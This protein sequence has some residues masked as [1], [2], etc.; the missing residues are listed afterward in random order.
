MAESENSNSKQ[1]YIY[2]ALIALL[3]GGLIYTQVKL[4]QSKEEIKRTE[5]EKGQLETMRAELDKKYQDAMLEIENYRASNAG[6]DSLLNVKEHELSEKRA[7]IESLLAQVA[8]LKQSGKSD[9]ASMQKLIDEANSLIKELEADKARTQNSID[10]LITANK[11]LFAERDSITGE[12]TTTKIKKQVSEEENKLMK[13]RIDRASILSTANLQ[14]SAVHTKRNGKEDETSKAKD[15][16]KLKICFD[17]LQNKIAPKGETEIM[18]RVISPTGSTI[19]LSSLGSGTFVS[20]EGNSVPYTYSIKPDYQNETKTVCSYWQQ[21]M[22]FQSGKYSIEV[23]Q[24]GIL[25]GQSNF[26]LK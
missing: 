11:Q 23:Y 5:Q 21:D 4:S 12:L 1:H 6:L 10:S 15:A 25:I 16:E 17:L 20:D 7:R 19:Q 8:S 24:K 3:I 18:V 13:E 2:I 9:K 22:N 14:C 26:M